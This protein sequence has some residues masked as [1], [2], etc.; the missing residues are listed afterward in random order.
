MTKPTYNRLSDLERAAI[1]SLQHV[2]PQS[3]EGAAIRRMKKW[4][5]ISEA[6]QTRLWKLVH[7]Y[8]RQMPELPA[9]SMK[10]GMSDAE[11]VRRIH[12]AGYRTIKEAQI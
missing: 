6:G 3:G 1:E 5:R 4:N 7:K 8:R 12:Q 2:R 9:V 11:Q 10:P